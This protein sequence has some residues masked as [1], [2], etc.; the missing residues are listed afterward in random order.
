VRHFF[1][2]NIGAIRNFYLPQPAG[3]KQMASW[4]QWQQWQQKVKQRGCIVITTNG[5]C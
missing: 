5:S 3:I 4:Q 2:T 1:I